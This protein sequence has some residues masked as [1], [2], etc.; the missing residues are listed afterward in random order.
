MKKKEKHMKV[1]AK[2]I[3]WT[4]EGP[5]K[6]KEKHFGHKKVHKKIAMTSKKPMKRRDH[7]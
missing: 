6:K 3:N 1:R 5:S 7:E 4:H 2:K